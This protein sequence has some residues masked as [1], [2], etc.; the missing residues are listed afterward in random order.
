MIPLP[1]RSTLFPYTTLFRSQA[2]LDAGTIV[3]TASVVANGV[4]VDPDDTATVTTVVD[5]HPDL[6]ISKSFLTSQQHTSE[7]H[8]PD[9]LGHRLLLAKNVTNTANV[10]LTAV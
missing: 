6:A 5:Q 3:N 2:D 4:T 9:H 8:T 7:L 10:D 1:P